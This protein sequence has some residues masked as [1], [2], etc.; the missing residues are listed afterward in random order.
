[1]PLAGK[2]CVARRK[3]LDAGVL[4]LRTCGTALSILDSS[5]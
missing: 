2:H 3:T 1:M 5:S 4:L